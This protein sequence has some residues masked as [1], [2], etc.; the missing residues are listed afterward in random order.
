MS[1][2]SVEMQCLIWGVP[3]TLQITG[4]NTG[5]LYC[6]YSVFSTYICYQL[7]PENKSADYI[8]CILALS[9]PPSRLPF[10]LC[11]ILLSFLPGSLFFHLTF[12]LNFLQYFFLIILI[13]LFKKICLYSSTQNALKKLL[14]LRALKQ[15]MLTA[16]C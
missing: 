15:T 14:P 3:Q 2:S 1:N 9:F 8:M 11:L 13:L 5:L 16:F 10:L 7:V 6:F 12:Q 4:N